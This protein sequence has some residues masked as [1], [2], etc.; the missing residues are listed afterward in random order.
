MSKLSSKAIAAFRSI[1]YEQYAANGRTFPWRETKDPYNILV[2][3]IML[4]QTQ[5][6]RVLH[7]YAQ[8]IEAF[9]TI[10]SLAQGS[11][12][13]VLSLWQGLGYNRRALFL[14][15]AAEV[16]L[17]DHKGILP[18]TA[19][20]LSTLPG[21]GPYTASAV[22]TF[23][24]N[25]PC[26]CIETNIRA[27]YIHHFF[28]DRKKVHDNEIEPLV[29]QTLDNNDPRNWYYA[30]M[31]Y[32]VLLK[33]KEVNPT[34]KSAHYQKQ[35]RFEGSDRQ[36]RGA[37]IALLTSHKELTRIALH[38]HIDEEERLEKI[39]NQLI[40]EGMIKHRNQVYTIA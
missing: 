20:G 4:Q 34:R 23:A 29:E 9:P 32:G 12:Q 15:K 30:L 11:L 16:V 2:S 10:I 25:A 18:D 35:S 22:M 37:V 1:V 39:L 7:K 36:I 13:D 40:A 31:D 6:H 17:K 24:Y 5:T 14:K 3:E 21:I 28:T 8:F 38:E 19:E 33:K 27:V 26:V